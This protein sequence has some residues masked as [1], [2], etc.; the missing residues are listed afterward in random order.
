MQVTCTSRRC[1]NQHKGKNFVVQ[2]ANKEQLV[3][4]PKFLPEIRMLPDTKISHAQVIIDNL[5]GEHI[6]AEMA[7]EGA[8]H[9]DALRA[10]LTK[11]LNKL[12]P[13]MRREYIRTSAF[14]FS[15]ISKDNRKLNAYQFC[16]AAVSS[17]TSTGLIGEDLAH[18]GGWD[19]IVMEYFPEAWRIREALWYWP[20]ALRPLVKPF[21]VRNTQLDAILVKAERFL[22]EPVRRRREPLNPDVDILKFLAEYNE[23]LRKI[24]MQVVGIITGVLNTSAHTLTQAVYDLC[25]HPEYITDIRAEAMDALASEGGQWTLGVTK[26]LH[27]LDS[28]LKESLRLLAPEGL[29][30]TRVATS[31]GLS[32]GT[33]IPKGTYL[34]VAGQAMALDPEFYEKPETFNGR[35][36]LSQRATDIP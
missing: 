16:Y 31:F 1:G 23:P 28:F 5:V 24:A 17:I 18:Y 20:R 35:R 34:A 12:L 36:F 21:L 7:M 22:E 32:D 15:Q 19:K 25:A 33:W 30:V 2:T 10:P 11:N 26:K 14:L 8:Q 29:A 6:G 13:V 27:L 9:I 4:A 3:I